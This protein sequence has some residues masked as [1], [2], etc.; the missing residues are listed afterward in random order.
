M[1]HRRQ[2]VKQQ[3]DQEMRKAWIRV[4]NTPDGAIG[5]LVKFIQLDLE[6][7]TPSEWMVIAYEVAS[8]VEAAGPEKRS[9]PLASASGWS[10]QAVPHDTLEY[11]LPNRKDAIGI[12]QT[13]RAHLEHLWEHGIAPI[14]FADLTL[15]VTAP[16][17][18]DDRHGS[19]L[20]S[21]KSKAKEFEYRVATLLANNAGRIR[22]C[23]ECKRI[24]VTTRCDQFFCNPRC[25][26]RVASRKWR[27]V[28]AKKLKQERT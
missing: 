22:A 2:D 7:L 9:L 25:Q 18:I 10:V 16:G 21:T 4:T 17:A 19:L 26:M 12:Q 28:N 6:E 13:I 23:Q 5:W 27:T 1:S 15:I 24:F 14:K 3:F 11:T 8:F 20:V